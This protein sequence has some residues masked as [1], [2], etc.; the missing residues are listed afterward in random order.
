MESQA[1]AG[2]ETAVAEPVFAGTSNGTPGEQ[3]FASLPERYLGAEPGSAATYQVDS[4]TSAAPGTCALDRG[5]LR[6]PPGAR[7][8]T[9]TS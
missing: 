3:A 6:G 9:P 8:A 7:A 5:P 4:A 1:H 2:A